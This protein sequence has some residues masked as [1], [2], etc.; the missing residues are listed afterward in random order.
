MNGK[1]YYTWL[2]ISGV[3]KIT[4]KETGAF[5]V[6]ASCNIGRRW[7]QHLVGNALEIQKDIQKL[8][9][10]KFTFEVLEQVSNE[11]LPERETYWIRELKPEYNKKEKGGK[12]GFSSKKRREKMKEINRKKA[13]DPTYRKNLSTA[14]QK[15]IQNPEY[16]ERMSKIMKGRP[17]SKEH[18]EALAEAKQRSRKNYLFP[19]GTIKNLASNIA[20]RYRNKG[21]ELVKLD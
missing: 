21:V 17:K 3:Y 11:E 13:Q 9:P 14:R 7:A 8:G 19:D 6:G 18:K 16:R 10:E 20:S 4:C 2:G 5:Y 1:E 12:P 15:V